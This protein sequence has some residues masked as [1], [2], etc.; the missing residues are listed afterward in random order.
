MLKSE[1]NETKYINKW[2]AKLTSS[3]TTIESYKYSEIVTPGGGGEVKSSMWEG[4]YK[5]MGRIDR[6]GQSK[7]EKDRILTKYEKQHSSFACRCA[8]I[9]IY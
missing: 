8:S 1:K 6:K 7:T 9:I 4:I 5:V 3:S 2:T